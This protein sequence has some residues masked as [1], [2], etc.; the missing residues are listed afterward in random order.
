[1]K[2]RLRFQFNTE[3]MI[4]AWIASLPAR[5]L[6]RRAWARYYLESTI[7]HLVAHGGEPPSVERNEDW[8]PPLYSYEFYP[9]WWVEYTVDNVRRWFR[10]PQRVIT[11][12]QVR[13]GESE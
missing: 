7:D 10:E 13:R 4:E 3:P 8:S 5:E 6:D 2:V 12:V 9:N 11:V 1:M